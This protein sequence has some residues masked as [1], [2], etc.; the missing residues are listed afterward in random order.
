[1]TFV[2]LLC[3]ARYFHCKSLMRENTS[4]YLILLRNNGGS[5]VSYNDS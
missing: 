1:M 2:E 4:K 3:A 5:G